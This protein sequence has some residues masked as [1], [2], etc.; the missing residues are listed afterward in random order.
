MEL[1]HPHTQTAKSSQGRVPETA[2]ELPLP[3]VKWVA[4]G[5]CRLAQETQGL[6]IS[7]EGEMGR[8]TGGRFQM[9]GTRVYGWM[10]QLEV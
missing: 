8:E 1:G 5:I 2:S 10:I 3:Y 6:C 7:L 4:K 9:E